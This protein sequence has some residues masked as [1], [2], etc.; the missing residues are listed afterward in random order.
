MGNNYKVIVSDMDDTLL[1]SLGKISDENREIIIQAQKKGVKI[2]L[3]SGR[4]TFAMREAGKE[5]QMDKYGGY[6]IAFNGG[7]ITSCEKNEEL[8]NL[9]LSKD[10]I[11]ELY[12]FSKRNKVHIVTYSSDEIISETN[13]EYIDIEIALTGMKHKKVDCFKSSIQSSGVKCI[14]L[15]EPEYLKSVEKKLKEEMGDRYS[16]AI[17]KPFFLEVTKKNVDKGATLLRLA[18]KLQIKPEEIICIG[19]SFN[20]V[21]MLKVA[22]LSVAVSNSKKEIKEIVDFITTSNDENGVAE[23][24]KKY[25]LKK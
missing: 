4:P 16:I 18:E 15:E 24:I 22:G 14:M 6:L 3:A 5:L 8:F 25:I 20:D 10:E 9:A 7:I 11:H 2:I 21:S 19:D 13:S 1:N 17:S 23:V 12:D